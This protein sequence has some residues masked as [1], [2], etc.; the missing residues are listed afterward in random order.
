LHAGTHY[1]TIAGYAADGTPIPSYSKPPTT[2]DLFQQG[3]V[4]A[5]SA[6]A[7]YPMRSSSTGKILYSPID[8]FNRHNGAPVFTIAGEELYDA[9][10]TGQLINSAYEI[11]HDAVKKVKFDSAEQAIAFSRAM[12]PALSHLRLAT[13]IT[14]HVPEEHQECSKPTPSATWYPRK[15]SPQAHRAAST[16]SDYPSLSQLGPRHTSKITKSKDRKPVTRKDHAASLRRNAIINQ[17]IE[18]LISAYM[19]T[20]AH[21]ETHTTKRSLQH[22]DEDTVDWDELTDTE[23]HTPAKSTFTPS[24]LTL[25]MRPSGHGRKSPAA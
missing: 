12:E 18:D 8:D 15:I 4:S 13:A 21:K 20:K 23:G 11:L 25:P 17:S 14:A 24:T 5:D 16:S 1:D 19:F 9:S 2:P 3:S 7:N 10:T 6:M 22:F